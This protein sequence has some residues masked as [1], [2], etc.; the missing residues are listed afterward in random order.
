M[1][2]SE[3]IKEL[4]PVQIIG[5]A[6]DLEVKGLAYDSRKVGPGYIFVALKGLA[7]DGHAFLAQAAKAGSP[8]VVVETEDPSLADL[9][10]VVVPDT[11]AA[12]SRLAHVFYQRPSR[13]MRTV[14]ITGTNGKTTVSYLVESV[15]AQQGPVGVIGT[16]DLRWPGHREPAA[17]TTP[18]SLDI[19]AALAQMRADRADQAVLEVSSH[20]LAQKRADNVALDAAVF[21]NLSRDHLDYHKDMED[22]FQSK[23]RL[24][25]E[26][27][28]KWKKT[29]KKGLAVVF[30]DDARGAGLAAETRA[31]GV[32]TLTYGLDSEADIRPVDLELTIEGI[33]LTVK[34][35]MGV[36]MVNSP[37]VGRFNAANLLAGAAVG[38][39]LGMEPALVAQG[40]CSLKG[41]PG[42]LE[43]VGVSSQGPLVFVDYCHTDDALRQALSVL[44]P[45]CPGRLICV[46]GAGG[47]RDHGKRPLMGL[48]VA[49]GADLAVLTSDNPR[50]EDPLSI[51]EMIEPGLVE[52][53]ALKTLDPANAQSGAYVT[54][55]DRAKAIALAVKSAGPGDVILI[56]GKGHEDYQIIGREKRHFDDRQEAARALGLVWPKEAANA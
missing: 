36:F 21:T 27:L 15:L 55:P 4:D 25:T 12:L 20:A 35:P 42:R 48:A 56:G 13:D 10:Q 45:L 38:L 9:C 46:F 32:E 1:K 34:S 44:R 23:K 8:V 53:G 5:A 30:N 41:V 29:G 54:E 24:F 7:A 19:H 22:Y 28:P 2:F 16:V 37:L 40:L 52:G 47:D 39:G 33:K 6:P 17:M 43:K 50:T 18:E 3:L 49:R 26:L 11:R 14:G 51:M 31:L